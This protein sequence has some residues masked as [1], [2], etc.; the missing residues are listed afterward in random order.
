MLLKPVKHYHCDLI[1]FQ[2]AVTISSPL[3]VN[4]LQNDQQG[5]TTSVPN[6]TTARHNMRAAPSVKATGTKLKN[7]FGTQFTNLPVPGQ[8]Q[9]LAPPSGTTGVPHQSRGSTSNHLV[10]SATTS[11]A[12]NVLVNSSNNNLSSSSVSSSSPSPTCALSTSIALAS[13]TSSHVDASSAIQSIATSLA[14][15]VTNNS[16]VAGLNRQTGIFGMSATPKGPTFTGQ[17]YQ[18]T[19]QGSIIAVSTIKRQTKQVTESKSL[20]LGEQ[21]VAYAGTERRRHQPIRAHQLAISSG[22]I[23]AGHITTEKRVRSHF[24]ASKS[25]ENARQHKQ[26][27]GVV[28]Q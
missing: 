16:S 23:R 2:P 4:L 18:R 9:I 26:C 13:S 7:N 10:V 6:S 8:G 3:L 15:S 14:N 1:D 11:Q 22:A 21:T 27:S 5:P 24:V 28:G 20:F 25:N 12:N 17:R 19:P